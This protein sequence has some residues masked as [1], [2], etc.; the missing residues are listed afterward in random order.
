MSEILR[1]ESIAGEA[2]IL[3]AFRMQGIKG[4]H[5]AMLTPALL[6]DEL[7]ISALGDRLSFLKVQTCKLAGLKCN[8]CD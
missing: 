7:E 6:R 8:F 1:K 3:A 5:L 2:N 4:T